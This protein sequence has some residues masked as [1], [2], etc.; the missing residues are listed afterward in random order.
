MIYG[1]ENTFL[2]RISSQDGQFHA[3]IDF[4]NPL[5][6][7]KA[8][9]TLK[10]GVLFQGTDGNEY[11]FQDFDGKRY[12]SIYL[13]S[14]DVQAKWLI[15]KD[16]SH[17]DILEFTGKYFSN[18]LLRMYEFRVKDDELILI[19]PRGKSSKLLYFN[20]DIFRNESQRVKFISDEQNAVIGFRMSRNRIKNLKFERMF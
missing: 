17:E 2:L 7:P 5:G 4:I 12:Q 16:I 19:P 8:L 13:S 18:E 3:S 15:R 9:L 1:I 6:L 14:L 10:G 11:S 20:N